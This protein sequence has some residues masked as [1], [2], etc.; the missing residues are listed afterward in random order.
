[1]KTRAKLLV[2][3]VVSASAS[4]HSSFGQQN[5]VA[6]V[7]DPTKVYRV[8]QGLQTELSVEVPASPSP[9]SHFESV[10]SRPLQVNI[11]RWSIDRTSGQQTIRTA[12]FTVF[13]LRTGK[14]TVVVNGK[15]EEKTIGD[16]WT[17]RAGGLLTLQVKGETAVVDAETVS[18]K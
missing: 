3:S 9:R 11:Q 10:R 13:H 8:T 17:S 2:I 14:L 16:M 15:E 7:A 18:G 12:E 4:I 5:P 6:T 1:M